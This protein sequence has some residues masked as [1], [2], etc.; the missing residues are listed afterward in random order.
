MGTT[1]AAGAPHGESTYSGQFGG[2]G[3]DGRERRL[4]GLRDI[5]GEVREKGEVEGERECRRVERFQA[6]ADRS[7]ECSR[8]FWKTKQEQSVPWPSTNHIADDASGRPRDVHSLF[9]V[10]LV[11]IRSSHRHSH[12]NY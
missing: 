4:I 2:V 12:A 5:H 10:S 1:A 6:V 11:I 8:L 3:R 9:P 7:A